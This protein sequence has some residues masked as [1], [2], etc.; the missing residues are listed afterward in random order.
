MLIDQLN[1]LIDPVIRAGGSVLES[2]EEF[3]EPP[4][5]VLRYY[6]RPVRMSWVPI[7]GRA[8]SVVALVQQPVDVDGSKAGQERVLTRLAMAVNGRFPPWRG[9]VIGLTAVVLTAEPIGPNDDANL[10][11]VL[12]VKFRRMRVVPFGLFRVNLGQEAVA[13]A[14]HSSPDG[15]FPEPG[16]LGDALCERLRRYVPLIDV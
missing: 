11:S 4:L 10:R 1:D 6:R 5:D 7:V 2:G 3:R 13:L 12:E 14:I 15:L 9:L 16:Q 8:Q